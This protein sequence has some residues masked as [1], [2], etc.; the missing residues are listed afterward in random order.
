MKQLNGMR[1]VFPLMNL[2]SL[3]SS[4]ATSFLKIAR[5]LPVVPALAE[6][7]DWFSKY[8]EILHLMCDILQIIIINF[9]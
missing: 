2:Q 8:A 3:L 5:S 9:V 4:N 7:L 6:T 1:L